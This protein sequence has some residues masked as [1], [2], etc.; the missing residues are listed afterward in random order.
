MSDS[1]QSQGLHPAR[2]PCPSPS[3]RV[4]SNSCPLSQWCHPTILVHW[5]SDVIQPSCPLSSPSPP[6]FNLSQH[7]GLFQWGLS[8]HQ[9]TKVL[10]LQLQHQ[11]FQWIFR[12][13]FLVWLTLIKP[14][15]LVWSPC[16]PRSSQESSSA[17]QFKSI[18][19]SALKH[20][21]GPT[22]TSEHASWRN[23]SFMIPP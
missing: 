23:Q 4:C 2:L 7:Q 10:E 9:V 21:Y 1:L 5:V 15:G 12:V 20:L 14:D 6:T 13:V 19:S 11:S 18:N 3:P 22:L 8:L 16:C 17:P